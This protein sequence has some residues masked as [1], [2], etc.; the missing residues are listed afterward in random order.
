MFAEAA[1]GWETVGT[2]YS[3]LD[4]AVA[5]LR[6][7]CETSKSHWATWTTRRAVVT[8]ESVDTDLDLAIAA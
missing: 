5:M 7:P 4:R 1:G 8:E 3:H 2:A 6:E